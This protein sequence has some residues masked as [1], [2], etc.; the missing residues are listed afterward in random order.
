V[1]VE[2]GAAA[3]RYRGRTRRGGPQESVARLVTFSDAGG[4]PHCEGEETH[5]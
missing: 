2:P 1:R 4:A 5:S 3:V